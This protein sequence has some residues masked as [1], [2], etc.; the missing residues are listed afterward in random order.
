[1]STVSL[2]AAQAHSRREVHVP[3]CA[4]SCVAPAPVAEYIAACSYTRLQRPVVA[5]L[6][7]EMREPRVSQRT[8]LRVLL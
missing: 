7:P 8:L 3:A 6:A 2:A 1:M 5:Y 4:A